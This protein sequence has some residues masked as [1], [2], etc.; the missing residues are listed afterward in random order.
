MTGLEIILS[1]IVYLTLGLW[2][3]QKRDWYEDYEEPFITCVMACLLTPLNLIVV[4]FSQF[5]V[6]EWDN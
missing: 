1:I 2:I 4:L 6:R 5:I 3:C